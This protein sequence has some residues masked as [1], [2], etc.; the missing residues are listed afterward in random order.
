VSSQGPRL[1][2]AQ[3]AP[4]LEAVPPPG[5]GGTERIIDELVRELDRRGHDV[6]LFASGDSTTAGRLV[7]TVERALR[8]EG[9]V[10][11]DGPFVLATLDAVLRQADQ[12]DVIH[13]HLD[14]AGV[15]LARVSPTPVA[16]TFHGRLDR[17]WAARFLAD[18]P[19]GLCALSAGHAAAHPEVPWSIV[20]D[21]LSLDDAPFEERPGDAL[22]FVGRMSPEKGAADAVEIARR[23][24]RRLRV[25]AKEPT[26]PGERDYFENVFQPAARGAEVELLGELGRADRD[27]LFAESY[28][29]LMPGDWPEPFGLV[30]IESL[31]CGTPVVARRVGGIPEIVR[32]GVDGV[33]DDSMAAL[34]GRLD[35]VAGL[36][37]RAIRSS[38]LERFSATRM[39][40]D[41][42]AVYAQLLAGRA[43]RPKVGIRIDPVGVRPGS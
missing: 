40:D 4:P 3:V 42:E 8:P 15:L 1:R 24:G 27:R 21:G 17:P 32:D 41:Y 7:P 38:V 20:P 29:S 11:E 35:E 18:P 26:V 36:D 16:V 33:V 6:T 22:C 9:R 39:T 14:F 43:K 30:A 34:A 23:S 31:A 10:A 37:R 19:P 5:Y 25:A 2:I 13:A 28:A 12:F